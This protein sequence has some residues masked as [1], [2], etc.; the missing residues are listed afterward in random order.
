MRKKS[1]AELIGVSLGGDGERVGGEGEP[2]DEEEERGF[3]GARDEG[4]AY[5]QRHQL[6][7]PGKGVN[8]KPN[9]EK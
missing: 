3:A 5:V 6:M 7:T 8:E 2:E 4:R 1:A 9:R